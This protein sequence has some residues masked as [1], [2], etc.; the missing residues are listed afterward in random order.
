MLNDNA[1][2]LTLSETLEFD[3]IVFCSKVNDVK[4][5]EKEKENES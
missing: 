4:E 1:S 2:L 3:L 5:K